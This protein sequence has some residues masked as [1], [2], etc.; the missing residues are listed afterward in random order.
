MNFQQ[1]IRECSLVDLK[2]E[3]DFVFRVCKMTS[4]ARDKGVSIKGRSTSKGLKV[5]SAC[6]SH[7]WRGCSR[8]LAIHVERHAS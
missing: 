5:D 6:A 4:Q 3:I 7:E 2:K 1:I 8:S